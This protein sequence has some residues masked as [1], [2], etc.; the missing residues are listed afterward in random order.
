MAHSFKMLNLINKC[1]DIEPGVQGCCCSTSA[2][3]DPLQKPP[4]VHLQEYILLLEYFCEISKY[5]IMTHFHLNFIV[6][7]N[8]IYSG[9]SQVDYD[10]QI[11]QNLTCYVGLYSKSKGLSSVAEVCLFTFLVHHYSYCILSE[12]PC[13]GRCAS[14]S[15]NVL[16]GDI[17]VFRYMQVGY[18][19]ITV[20]IEEINGFQSMLSKI[21]WMAC[22]GDC[23]SVTIRTTFS[24]IPTTTEIFTCDP[25]SV[26]RSLSNSSS[27]FSISFINFY[28]KNKILVIM[29]ELFKSEKTTILWSSNIQF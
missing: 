29:E 21:M 22:N 7:T 25:S 10:F 13:D 14:L 18:P 16:G 24:Q 23:V 4:K 26:C 12:A 20:I 27:Y 9:L 6:H 8:Y 5:N 1:H 2:C 3:M 19:Y 11:P 15:S 28:I 17:T